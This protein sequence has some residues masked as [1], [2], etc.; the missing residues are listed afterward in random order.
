V[1]EKFRKR[2]MK[3]QRLPE[4]FAGLLLGF[5]ADQKIQ[6]IRMA[7]EETGNEVAA[8]IPGGTC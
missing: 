4:A 3:L 5:R 6:T 2:E 7:G 8:E 1:F